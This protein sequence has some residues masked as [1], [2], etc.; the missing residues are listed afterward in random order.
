MRRLTPY[1]VVS[2]LLLV[3]GCSDAYGPSEAERATVTPRSETC[4]SQ[5]ANTRC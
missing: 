4:E 2:A 1:L 3:A 5:G